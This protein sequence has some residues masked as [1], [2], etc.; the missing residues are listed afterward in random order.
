MSNQFSSFI[1]KKILGKNQNLISIEE[2]YHV[3]ATLLKNHKVSAVIDAGAS[4]GHISRR[5]LRLFPSACAYAFEP[6]PLYR[7]QLLQ[8]AKEDPRFRPQFVALSDNEGSADLLITESPGCTSLFKPADM[9]RE[10]DSAGSS[11][12]ASE[13]VEVC[14]ID[15]W[16]K[17]NGDAA[18]E[19]IK[20]DIQG[21][22]LKALDGAKQVLEHSTLLV[23]TEVWFNPCYEGGAIFSEI[24]SFMR[25]QGFVLYD[26]YKPKYNKKGVIMWGN[27]IFVNLRKLEM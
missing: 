24:D 23:Y 9:L 16:A 22:E 2:P 12:E 11:V 18:I 4:D 25:R 13:K 5:F 6:N 7:Q 8:Y 17:R 26:I 19:I 10:Y 27:A 3:M 21:G 15:A 14:T 20:F 1:K